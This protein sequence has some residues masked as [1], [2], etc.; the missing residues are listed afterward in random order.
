MDKIALSEKEA[1]GLCCDRNEKGFSWT[2]TTRLGKLL[3]DAE[4]QFDPRDPSWTILGIEFW[5]G[6][7]PMVWFP[8]PG[9]NVSVLLSEK[10]RLDT[11]EAQFELAQE[12]VHLLAPTGGGEAFTI[13]EG[14]ATIFTRQNSPIQIDQPS[15]LTAQLLVKPLLEID[16]L[17][18]L[19]LRQKRRAFF[20]FTP[21][22][23]RENYPDV[24]E[25]D[26]N[27]L[28]VPFQR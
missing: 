23:I 11:S 16:P 12:I 24:T 5:S 13:E 25:S 18:I 15:Y 1:R 28:C 21:D 14:V 27:A 17:S 22:F 3:F 8:G 2:L 26:A 10:A 20:D 19:K 9:R 6:D 4:Q 7:Y